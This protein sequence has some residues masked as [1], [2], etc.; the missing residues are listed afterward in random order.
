LDSSEILWLLFGDG[1][2]VFSSALSLNHWK[3]VTGILLHAVPAAA[4]VTKHVTSR[5]FEV[6]VMWC[7]RGLSL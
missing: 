6:R 5:F 3:T 7:M 1:G 2:S 4:H